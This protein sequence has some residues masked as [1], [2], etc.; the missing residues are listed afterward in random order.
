MKEKHRYITLWAPLILAIVFY[1]IGDVFLKVGNMDIGSTI[2]SLL[3]GSFWIA[4]ILSIPIVLA[5][6]LTFAS[7][8]VMGVVLSKNDLGTSEGL[9]LAMS[10]AGLF[11][12]GILFFSEVVSTNQIIGV[13]LLI[14]GI[15]LVSDREEAKLMPMSEN[16]EEIETLNRKQE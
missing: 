8:I 14:G 1:I 15:I 5:F 6:G 9:F 3:Q 11:V 13:I 12:F 7:K 4:L 10:I 2:G 16:E